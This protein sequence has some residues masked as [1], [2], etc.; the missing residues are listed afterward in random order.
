MAALKGP[1]IILTKAYWPCA[2]LQAIKLPLK[3][4]VQPPEGQLTSQNR[5]HAASVPERVAAAE[6][7]EVSCN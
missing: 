4:P 2:V 6:L 1:L 7:L 3:D 5:W